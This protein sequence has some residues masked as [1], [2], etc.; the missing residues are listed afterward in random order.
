MIS[1]IPEYYSSLVAQARSSIIEDRIQ[2]GISK[3]LL[4][5]PEEPKNL[6]MSTKMTPCR[7]T[8]HDFDM[9]KEKQ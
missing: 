7:T 8:G 6:P 9:D 2:G 1:P 5:P 3:C 4:Q